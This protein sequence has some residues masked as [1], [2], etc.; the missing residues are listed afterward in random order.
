MKKKNN[1]DEI[2]LPSSYWNYPILGFNN[3]IIINEW[4]EQVLPGYTVC[5]LSKKNNKSNI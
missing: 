1:L 3:Y 5:I 2:Y 4:S